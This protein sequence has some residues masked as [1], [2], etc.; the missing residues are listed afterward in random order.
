MKNRTNAI[1]GALIAAILLLTGCSSQSESVAVRDDLQSQNRE[2][3]LEIKNLE[4]KRALEDDPAAVRYVYVIDFGTIIG[5]YVAEGKISS[6]SSQI[7]PEQDLIK[8]WE[9][10]GNGE[11][12]YVVDSAKDDGSFGPGDPGV[13]FFTPEGIM[14]ET[15]L[16]TLI[17]TAPIPIDVPRLNPAK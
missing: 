17:S 4:K 10:P 7:A 12:L 15:D 11:D 5:Y 6:N 3:S 13:F 1:A 9:S 2:D 16:K 8:G 14:V